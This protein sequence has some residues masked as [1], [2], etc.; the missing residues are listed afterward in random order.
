MSHAESGMAFSFY[1][2]QRSPDIYL[3]KSEIY[4]TKNKRAILRM[5]YWWW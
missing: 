2:R 4:E 1:K 3:I 5:V